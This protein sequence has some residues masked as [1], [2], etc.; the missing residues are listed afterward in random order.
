MISPQ[1]KEIL[2]S[3]GSKIQV[4]DNLFS[5]QEREYFFQFAYRSLF[6]ARNGASD[7][8]TVSFNPQLNLHCQYSSEDNINFKLINSP[9]FVNNIKDDIGYP[10]KAWLNLILPGFWIHQHSDV[11]A[12]TNTEQITLMYFASFKWEKHFGGDVIFCNKFTG[13]KERIVE[14]LPG[15]LILFN[16]SIPHITT[17][18]TGQS[19]PRYT[20]VCLFDKEKNE[21]GQ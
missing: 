2:L 5:W 12:R 7:A 10:R 18:T 8:T 19:L 13:E 4:I 6:T 16:S 17:L 14:Y 20:Y 21:Y 3:C 11:N 9:N 15:R 1:Q